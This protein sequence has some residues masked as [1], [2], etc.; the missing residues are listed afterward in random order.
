RYP[1][2]QKLTDA[3]LKVGYS[4]HELGRIDEAKQQL[5]D[6]KQR[7]PGTTAAR[8]AE[9]RLRKINASSMPEAAA[10]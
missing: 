7:F 9:E 5:E 3:L 4:F 10:R 2:S 6:L 8:L 1:D